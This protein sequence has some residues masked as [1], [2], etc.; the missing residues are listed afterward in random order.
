[1]LFTATLASCGG[2]ALSQQEGGVAV[3]GGGVLLAG[4]GVLF[5]AWVLVFLRRSCGVSS[6]AQHC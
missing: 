2:P 6:S 1:M 5:S 4:G 3:T